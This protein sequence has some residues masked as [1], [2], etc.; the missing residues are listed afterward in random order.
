MIAGRISDLVVPADNSTH[1]YISLIIRP[2]FV[3]FNRV[4]RAIISKFPTTGQLHT[5]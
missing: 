2:P 3:P 4:M 1:A 5:R